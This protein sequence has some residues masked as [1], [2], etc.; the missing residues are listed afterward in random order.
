MF[1][2]LLTT[3]KRWAHPQALRGGGDGH[4]YIYVTECHSALNRKK[5]LPLATTW[6]DLEDTMLR[7]ISPTET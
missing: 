6:M 7:E 3:A 2:A 5:T 1:T 4:L